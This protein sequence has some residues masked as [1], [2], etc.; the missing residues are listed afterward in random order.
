M[1]KNVPPMLCVPKKDGSLQTTI[2]CC[3]QNEN[4]HKD[5]TPFS[6][7]DHIWLDVACKRVRSTI[8]LSNAYEQVRTISGNV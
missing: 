5:V 4:T 3:K 1:A 7:Q 8:D 6:D 2:D